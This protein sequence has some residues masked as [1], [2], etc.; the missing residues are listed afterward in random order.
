ME[1]L[2]NKENE[3]DHRI[4]AEVKEGPADC[5]TIIE[6]AAALKEMKRQSPKVVKASS[7]ND[8]STG[9]IGTHWILD[10]CRDRPK[11]G[12]GFGAE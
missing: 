12:F 8:T 9:D 11:F 6:V 1:K 10:L 3:W 2:T 7:R 5:I 4:M